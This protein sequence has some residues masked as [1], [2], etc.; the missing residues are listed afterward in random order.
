M[1]FKWSK[2][3]ACQLQMDIPSYLYQVSIIFSKML[4]SE[5]HQEQLDVSMKLIYIC[6]DVSCRGRT[7]NAYLHCCCSWVY[8]GLLNVFFFYFYIRFK[9]NFFGR[10]GI[11]MHSSRAGL[12]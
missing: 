3:A 12:R 7:Q 5:K 11:N 9:N 2:R 10:M 4:P 8:G 1:T 6:V